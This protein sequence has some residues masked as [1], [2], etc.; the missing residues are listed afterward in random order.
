M[1]RRAGLLAL[2]L[3]AS[4]G[5]L[6][7]TQNA[8]DGL[9]LMTFN[10]RY[11]SA[12]DGSNSWPNR[13]QLVADII[14]RNAPDVL[15]IQEG[16]A[17]QLDELSPVLGGYRKLGQHRDGGSEGEFSG[18]YVNERRVRITQWG[19]FWLSSTPDSVGSRGW[20]AALPRTVVWVEIEARDGSDP[21]RVYGTHFDHRGEVARL[22]SSRLIARHADGGPA[23][24]VMGDLNADEGSDPLGVFW[25]LGYRSAFR[26][27]HPDRDIGTFNGFRDPSGGR[28]IDHILLDRRLEAR[29]AEIVVDRIGGVWP[30]DHFP[31]TALLTGPAARSSERPSSSRSPGASPPPTRR[32]PAR[33]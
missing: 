28:R 15:A 7:A 3:A 24:V 5:E 10:I 6:V 14:A 4:G 23:A 9:R 11:G 22:E 20:D 13:R 16:L 1:T 26:T 19:Q 18:L 8:D 27:V 32:F 25:D 2:I 29:A 33:P 30:S 21:I 31:V 17:F 12:D